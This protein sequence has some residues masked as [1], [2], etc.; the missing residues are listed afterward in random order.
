MSVFAKNNDMTTA[1][2]YKSIVTFAIPVALSN[3]MQQLYSAVDGAVLGAFVGKEAVAATAVSHLIGLMIC[4]FVGLGSGAGV[5][6]ARFYG[7]KD[8][9]GVSRAV[10][11]AV[12]VSFISGAI[13]T[14]AGVIFSRQMLLLMNFDDVI[15]LSNTYL[16]IIFAGMIAKIT[17]NITSGILRAVGDSRRTFYYLV[18]GSVTNVLLDLL[19]VAVFRFGVAGAA[20]ATIISEAVSA[21]LCIARLMR[22]D[23]SYKLFISKLKIHK[24]MFISFVKIGVPMG[25]LT[26]AYALPN[27]LLQTSVNTFGVEAMAGGS[28]YSK[29]GDFT[30]VILASLEA[31]VTTFVSQNIGAGKLDRVKKGTRAGILVCLAGVFVMIL[32]TFLVAKPIIGALVGYDEKSVYYGMMKMWCILPF[33]PIGVV[34]GMLGAAMQG[35]GASL[36]IMIQGIIFTCVIRVLIILFILPVYHEIY[37]IY[38]TYPFTWLLQMISYIFYYKFGKWMKTKI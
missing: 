31:A 26:M 27:T 16:S 9:D 12:T 23:E 5:V 20:I 6:V 37:I 13:L 30:D 25:F 21:A 32:L 18:A 3:L 22:A 14:V 28:A 35:G 38:L 1:P 10:H 19:F 15:D 8:S 33:Y 7:A 24:K 36:E 11:T 17:Y 4:L 29:I 2:I 34:A